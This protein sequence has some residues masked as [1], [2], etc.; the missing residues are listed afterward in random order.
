MQKI[1]VTGA[2][3]QIGSELTMALRE[4]Y[5]NENVIA[6]GHKKKPD[7]PLLESGPFHFI[8]CTEINTVAEMVKK[9]K[10]DTIYH[11]AALLS[12]VAEEK[13]QRAWNVNMIGLYNVLEVARTYKCS[14]FTPSS[15]GAFGPSTPLDKTPQDTIQRP[16]TM[17]G[18]TK[19][20]GELLCDY[21]FKRFGVDTRGVRYPGIISYK[22]PPGGGTTDYAVEIYYH[23]IKR[24][25]YTCYL[26]K[27]TY[28]D[29]M[30]MPDALKAAIDLMEASPAK[31]KHRNAFNVTA[32]SVATE[33]IGAEIKKI[34]PE[35]AMDFN[36]DPLR[37]AIADSWPN[38]MD[39][40]AAR[41]EWG[42]QPEYDL[43]SMTQDM[44]GK[45]SQK[46]GIRID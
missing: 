25:K 46:L 34:I 44:M 17:Y 35:F 20:A 9:Y 39:D 38:S 18:I 7:N 11:L 5:G 8:D 24:R 45:L 41:E 6:A 12:A 32:M 16:N 42:W 1:L 21:Y 14:V 2:A 33:D 31:L 3:G 4:G 27:G 30:Y 10:V 13:P 37:Q 29:M 40:S 23:A 19:V 15:I 43:V 22:T 26:K 36:I 28:L